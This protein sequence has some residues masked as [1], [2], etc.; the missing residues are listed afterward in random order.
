VLAA[1]G[2]PA[3]HAGRLFMTCGLIVT[4]AGAAL[5]FVGGLALAHGLNPLLEAI[6][7]AFD[8]RLFDRRLFQ[9]DRLP[10]RTDPARIGW[11]ALATVVCGTL[12]TLLPSWRAARLDPVEA[13]RHE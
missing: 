12:F 6:E 1:L 2:A 9:F 11:Y 3:L 5:G 10:I 13:L 8:W 7:R 4:A